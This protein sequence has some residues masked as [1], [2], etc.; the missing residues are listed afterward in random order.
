MVQYYE[1]EEEPVLGKRMLKTKY[2]VVCVFWYKVV[3]SRSKK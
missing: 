1:E 2:G 3:K